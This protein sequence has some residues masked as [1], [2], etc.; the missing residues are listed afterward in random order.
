MFNNSDDSL[1]RLSQLLRVYSD[2]IPIIAVGTTIFDVLAVTAGVL[3]GGNGSTGVA[4]VQE[5]S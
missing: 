1:I 2:A 5:G 4:A 3:H